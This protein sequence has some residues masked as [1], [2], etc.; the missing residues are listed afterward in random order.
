MTITAVF[1]GDVH[2]VAAV[3]FKIKQLQEMGIHLQHQVFTIGQNCFQQRLDV[4][5]TCNVLFDKLIQH[6]PAYMQ[7]VR[8][9]DIDF[10]Q[11][12]FWW[13]PLPKWSSSVT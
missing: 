12:K 10:S 5:N 8:I 1:A 2:N 7:P 3:L 6:Q 9:I 4:I 13:G 11:P